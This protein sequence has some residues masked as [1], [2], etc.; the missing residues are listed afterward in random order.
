MAWTR[1][2][3]TQVPQDDAQDN[4]GAILS[5]PRRSPQWAEQT[6]VERYPSYFQTEMATG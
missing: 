3:L 2:E 5:S 1:L 6:A 4:H